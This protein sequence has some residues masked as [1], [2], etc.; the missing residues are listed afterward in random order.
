MRMVIGILLSLIVVNGMAAPVA[1]PKAVAK[2]KVVT[3][4]TASPNNTVVIAGSTAA[5]TDAAGNVWTISAAGAVSVVIA[6]ATVSTGETTGATEIAYVNGVIW[7]QNAGSL[8]YSKT[9]PTVA[10][11]PAAGTLVSPLP[12]SAT[13]PTAALAW[14]APTT[15]TDGSAIPSTVAIT[16]NVY[17]SC[18]S[19]TSLVKVASGITALTDTITSGLAAGTT[20]WWTVSATA[21]AVEGGQSNV[22]TKVFPVPPPVIFP[23]GTVTLTVR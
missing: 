2:P 3:A 19:A 4:T 10:W 8:W 9:S 20:C 22:V 23:P 7:Q 18:T 21:N 17:Q 5:I 1:A 14:S 11:S 15:Y 13:A 12:A 6:G 16:Y